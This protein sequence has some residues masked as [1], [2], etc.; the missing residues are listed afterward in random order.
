MSAL[1]A[2][3]PLDSIRDTIESAADRQ[4]DGSLRGGKLSGEFGRG[5][6]LITRRAIVPHV[7]NVDG[8]SRDV[9]DTQ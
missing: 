1:N 4:T 8:G 5:S 6:A 7:W 3:E 9:S 2:N